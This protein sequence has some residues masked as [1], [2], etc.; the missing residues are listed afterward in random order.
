MGWIPHHMALCL[1]WSW[2]GIVPL[3]YLESH[4]MPFTTRATAWYQGTV[5]SHFL[6]LL[7]DRDCFLGKPWS[8]GRSGNCKQQRLYFKI[9]THCVSNSCWLDHTQLP[10]MQANPDLHMLVSICAHK[11]RSMCALCNLPTHELDTHKVCV[12]FCAPTFEKSATGSFLLAQSKQ[13]SEKLIQMAFVAYP[14]HME[15]AQPLSELE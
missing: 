5:E 12:Q 8:L 4:T 10:G 11:L 9:V 13:A 6:P 3:V 1:W 14:Y 7:A 2:E 15:K